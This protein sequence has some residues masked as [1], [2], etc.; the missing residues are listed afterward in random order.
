MNLLLAIG[1]SE[2]A[3]NYCWALLVVG[4]LFFISAAAKEINKT[5]Q[6]SLK[7]QQEIA[8]ALRELADTKS[9]ENKQP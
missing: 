3:F 7:A 4:S 9:K 5:L 1:N 8:E 6:A 2:G